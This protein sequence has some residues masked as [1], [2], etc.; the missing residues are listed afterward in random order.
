VGGIDRLQATGVE[1]GVLVPLTAWKR[2][3]TGVRTEP[4]EVSLGDGHSFCPGSG[5]EAF[6]FFGAERLRMKL[7]RFFRGGVNLGVLSGA[8]RGTAL[9]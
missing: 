2:G 6:F 3:V 4:R 8:A 7:T 9:G 5:F 1:Q